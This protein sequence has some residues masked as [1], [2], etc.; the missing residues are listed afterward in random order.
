MSMS[1]EL[2][3]DFIAKIE[4]W[5]IAEWEKFSAFPLVDPDRIDALHDDIWG[6]REMGICQGLREKAEKIYA[7]TCGYLLENDSHKLLGVCVG[8]ADRWDL[9]GEEYDFLLA[10]VR[11]V[12]PTIGVV[13]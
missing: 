12:D 1:L 3:Q 6:P 10:P 4:E 13:S 11:A 2:A 8:L 9:T 5:G 7:A